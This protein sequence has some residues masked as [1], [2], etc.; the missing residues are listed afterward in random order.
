MS[1]LRVNQGLYAPFK[2]NMEKQYA[3]KANRLPCLRSSN[4]MLSV[5]RGTDESIDVEDI[6]NSEFN[7][8]FGSNM[9]SLV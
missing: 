3:A 9:G 8:K 5:L 2:F 1:Q 4:V 6:F 7:S